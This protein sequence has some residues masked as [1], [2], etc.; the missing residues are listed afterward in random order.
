MI[1]TQYAKTQSCLFPTIFLG[2]LLLGAIVT[3]G[4]ALQTAHDRAVRAERER[5]AERARTGEIWAVA[6]EAYL[7]VPYARYL[8]YRRLDELAAQRDLFARLD[9]VRAGL[10]D[11]APLAPAELADALTLLAELVKIFYR[12]Y[13]GGPNRWPTNP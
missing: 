4:C 11:E 6:G 9:R 10:R 2:T 3:A 1:E 8:G 5:A 13:D 7:V 12:I